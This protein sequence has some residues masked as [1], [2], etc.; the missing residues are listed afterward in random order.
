MNLFTDHHFY[1]GYAHVCNGKPCQDYAL[2]GTYNGMAYVIISDGCSTGGFTD[3]GSRLMT[4]SSRSAIK[5]SWITCRDTLNKR[6][7]SEIALIQ[8]IK[9]SGIS[10]PM[11]L[12]RD[13]LLATNIYACISDKGGFV[14][15]RGDGVVAIKYLDGRIVLKRYD[16]KDNIPFYPAYIDDNY[17]SFIDIHG[18]DKSLLRFKEDSF[19]LDAD[20]KIIS[21][22]RQNLYSVEDGIKG[23]VIGIHN[24]LEKGIEFIAIFSDGVT[25]IENVKWQDAV[26]QLMSFKTLRGKFT[27]R[28]LNGAL[29]SFQKVGRGPI[30]DIA[31]SVIR[32]EKDEAEVENAI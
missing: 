31:Y 4:F 21:E 1:I 7:P 17:V 13:D 32:I 6:I 18:G 8:R 25:Q 28:R 9:L 19:I 15:L 26:Y 20:G 30:D 29:K 5:E 22:P 3:V 24:P 2:S 12:V 23:A 14:H 27:I 11:D 16:W 10:D